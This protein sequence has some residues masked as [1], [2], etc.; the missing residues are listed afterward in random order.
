M[1][2][3]MNSDNES[4][5]Q[6]DEEVDQSLELAM[7]YAVCHSYPPGLTKEKKRAVGKRASTLVV[8]KGEVFLKTTSEGCDPCR[9]SRDLN[10]VCILVFG[11]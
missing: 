6:Q 11:N 2:L 8:D 7:D 9:A 1:F 3:K 5:V 4:S 10:L